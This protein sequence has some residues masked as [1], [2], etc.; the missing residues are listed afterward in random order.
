MSRILEKGISI[1]THH[2]Q[3]SQRKQC[4]SCNHNADCAR[5]R[6]YKQDRV[7]NQ[8]QQDNRFY[9]IS[10]LQHAAEDLAGVGIVRRNG[11]NVIEFFI[12]QICSPA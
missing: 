10:W 3:N 4:Y 9:C 2:G 5:H 11:V 1:N 12:V 6:Y 8:N 7:S